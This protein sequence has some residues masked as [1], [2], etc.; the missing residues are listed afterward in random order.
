VPEPE[1]NK[2]LSWSTFQYTWT[3][4]IFKENFRNH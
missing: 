2:K 3:N 4:K 1:V